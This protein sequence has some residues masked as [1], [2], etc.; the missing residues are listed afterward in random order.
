MK[1]RMLGVLLIMFISC[2]SA[3]GQDITMPNQVEYNGRTYIHAEGWDEYEEIRYADI[4]GDARDEIIMRIKTY[5]D[6]FP[7]SFTLI[8]DKD[9]D[10]EYELKQTILNG[11]TPKKMDIADIDYDGVQDIILY[12]HSGNHY[13]QLRVYSFRDGVY[14]CLF[15][16]GTACFKYDVMVS[17]KPTRILIGRENWDE[18]GFCYANSG[19]RALEEVWEW[20]G[21]EF[22]YSPEHSTVRMIPEIEAIQITADNI[23]GRTREIADET[24]G[25]DNKASGVLKNDNVVKGWISGFRFMELEYRWFKD[26][27]RKVFGKDRNDVGYFELT[28]DMKK[29]IY[30]KH[31]KEKPW[32]KDTGWMPSDFDEIWTRDIAT[33][34]ERQLIANNFN[35]V[36]K[37]KDW[38]NHLGSFDSIHIS[39]DGQMMYFLCQNSTSNAVFFMADI[40][41]KN[42]KRIRD[43][44]Q[45]DMV[46]GSKEDGYYGFLVAGVKA[47]EPT[48]K[49]NEWA[50]ILFDP[51][52]NM[53]K[54]IKDI[55]SF[56]EKHVK[57]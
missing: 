33:G 48:D 2:S 26:F 55:D 43:A 39:P 54:E 8:Y 22:E 7:A 14:N 12:D 5:E 27:F 15:E 10:G 45:L 16:N 52:G 56:W 30:V 57:Q 32:D 44:H 25:K 23:L 42:I 53:V 28:P 9:D 19:E 6:D 40:N 29:V 31:V 21:A 36:K 34:E 1:T 41:G 18:E 4:D 35:E 17:D 24:D 47:I 38:K 3:M 20:N 51:E 50:S 11:E 46:A 13:T 49:P 37:N